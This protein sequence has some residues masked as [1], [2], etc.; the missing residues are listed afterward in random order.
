MRWG[1]YRGLRRPYDGPCAYD[2]ACSSEPPYSVH[3]CTPHLRGARS[4]LPA[5]A[6][7]VTETGGPRYKGNAVYFFIETA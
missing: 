4:L 3:G 1:A 7:A 5:L 2:R 6:E